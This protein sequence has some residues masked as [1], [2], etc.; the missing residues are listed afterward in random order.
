MSQ[1][2]DD[3]SRLLIGDAGLEKLR[4]SRILIAGAGG[5]G[6]YAAETLAR[7]GVGS[8][9][10]VDSDRVDI[11]NLNRQIIA[12]LP[13]VGKVKTELFRTRF[14][15]INPQLDFH[16]L[17]MYMD[18]ENIPGL[19]DSGFDFIIDAIDTISPKCSLITEAMERKIPIISS[20]GAGG[21]IDP[22]KVRYGMLCDTHNDGLARAVRT[23]LRKSGF[24]T[25]VPVVWSE[26]IPE[27][28]TV[29]ISG[30]RHKL[31]SPGS[32]SPVPSVFGIFMASY[33]MRKLM[34][35]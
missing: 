13:D 21:R 18:Q 15:S 1:R 17:E 33:A 32:M 28:Q 25:K 31:S 29:E 5:V 35:K 26:E 7:S 2:W 9:T 24:R 4:G 11:T 20:M 30:E 3:R 23:K 14:L 12:T 27:R 22:S 10:M 16:G 19:L 6:G 34:G 8:L